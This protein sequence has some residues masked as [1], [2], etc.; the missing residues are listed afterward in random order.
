MRKC[1]AYGGRNHTSERVKMLFKELLF[2]KFILFNYQN[3][4]TE[5]GGPVTRLLY[6]GG[7]SLFKLLEILRLKIL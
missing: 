4:Y 5:L 6:K 2:S 1:K 3:D 7:T